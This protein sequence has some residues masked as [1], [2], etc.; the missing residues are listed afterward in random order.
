MTRN[1]K[2]FFEYYPGK[3]RPGTIFYVVSAILLLS[4]CSGTPDVAKKEPEKT[5]QEHEEHFDPSQYREKETVEKPAEQAKP[6]ETAQ[7]T[8][9][10]IERVEKVM[11]FRIQLYSTT[12]I[13]DAE[14]QLHYL[15]TRIDSLEIGGAR[16][17][18]TFDAPYYKLRVGDFLNKAAADS[19]RDVLRENGLPEA[20]V[21]RDRVN[22]IT[23]IPLEK[24]E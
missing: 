15:R 13:D 14:E 17:D 4:A 23:R 16:L 19:L 3:I 24:M 18:M 6:T 20:W 21:V 9:S 11:G 8:K 1:S 12:G 22:R 10:W 7:E 2:H 5:L